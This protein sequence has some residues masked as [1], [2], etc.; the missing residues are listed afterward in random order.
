MIQIASFAS[1]W[2]FITTQFR[3]SQEGVSQ[4]WLFWTI[5]LG[6]WLMKKCWRNGFFKKS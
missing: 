1:L 3:F 5:I 2:E 4:S 6:M